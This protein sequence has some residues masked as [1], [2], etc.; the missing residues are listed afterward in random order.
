MHREKASNARRRDPSRSRESFANHRLSIINH[1]SSI[2]NRKAFTL[3]ELL[4]VISIVVMLI[5]ILLPAVQRVRKQAQAVVCQSKLRQWGGLFA[6]QAAA[7]PGETIVCPY[8]AP[9]GDGWWTGEDEAATVMVGTKKVYDW[10]GSLERRYGPAVWDLFLCPSASRLG[11]KEVTDVPYPWAYGDTFSAWWGIDAKSGRV[12]T[13]SYGFNYATAFLG[14]NNPPP[15]WRFN[16][17]MKGAA[18]AP[19]FFDCGVNGACNSWK[20]GPPPYENCGYGIPGGD[21]SYV[22]MNRHNGGI[23]SLFLDW[24]VR[25]VGLKEI[26]TL[27]WDEGWDTSGPWT[28]RGGALPEDWPAWTRGFKDY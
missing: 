11:P 18:S 10:S 13:Y 16:L 28:K 14:S 4:V 19:V 21:W 24:S 22:C 17:D 5:S 6:A 9:D 27:K 1:Q 20:A 25:K 2:I 3:I 15:G 8:A 12:N 7:N 26:W 23:N